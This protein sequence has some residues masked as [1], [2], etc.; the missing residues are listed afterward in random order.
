MVQYWH[1]F[2]DRPRPYPTFPH[3]C[4][5][6]MLSPDGQPQ[7]PGSGDTLPKLLV[8]NGAV[9]TGR[10]GRGRYVLTSGTRKLG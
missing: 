5:F 10:R 9:I 2:C 8:L 1:W 7:D 4:T 3:C 6:R